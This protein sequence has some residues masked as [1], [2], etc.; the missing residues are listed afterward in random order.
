MTFGM[1]LMKF[2]QDNPKAMSDMP[3]V[4]AKTLGVTL[5]SPNLAALWGTAPGRAQ[6]LPQGSGPGRLHPGHHTRRGGLP[7]HPRPP[8]RDH[9]RPGRS[10]GKLLHDHP[11][12]QKD[13]RPHPGDGR[14]GEQ[15]RCRIRRKG[16]AAR[17]GLPPHPPGRPPHEHERQHPHARPCM[18]PGQACMHPCHAPR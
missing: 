4:L 6:E 1:E 8:G 11:R 18:E 16:P 13:P 14:L 9:H 3:Y 15:H 17:S 5:G 2:I 7:G 12:G 10:G